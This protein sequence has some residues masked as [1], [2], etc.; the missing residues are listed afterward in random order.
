MY[1]ELRPWLQGGV[2]HFG[3]AIIMLCKWN[4]EGGF[5]INI[6]INL[7]GFHGIA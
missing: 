6:I 7:E 5:C 1:D 2:A 4:A 3:V